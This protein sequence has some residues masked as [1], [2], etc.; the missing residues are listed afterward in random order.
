M[1][2]LQMK[3][4]VLKPKGNDPYAEASRRAMSAY[5]AAIRS[6]NRELADQLSNWAL[7]ESSAAIREETTDDDHRL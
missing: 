1:S 5:A 7:D 2:G 3:Y 4:F 6:K